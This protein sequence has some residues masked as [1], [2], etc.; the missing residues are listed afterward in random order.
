MSKIVMFQYRYE[1]V[2]RQN[3]LTDNR[4][5]CGRGAVHILGDYLTTRFCGHPKPRISCSQ[6]V[7]C[8]HR[9]GFPETSCSVHDIR[10]S[11]R[12]WTRFPTGIHSREF[13]R[14]N[15]RT[16]YSVWDLQHVLLMLGYGRMRWWGVYGLDVPINKCIT[17]TLLLLLR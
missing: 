1:A 15:P 10:C 16:I 3:T 4:I 6:V 2:I 8:Y 13:I 17:I 11:I 12:G 7:M 9:L 5:S 14:F